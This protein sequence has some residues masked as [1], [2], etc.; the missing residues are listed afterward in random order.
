MHIDTV[1]NVMS[2]RAQCNIIVVRV[3]IQIKLTLQHTQ[4][5]QN[6]CGTH[7]DKTNNGCIW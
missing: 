7:H 1:H 3:H 5:N 6:G 4:P 2:L